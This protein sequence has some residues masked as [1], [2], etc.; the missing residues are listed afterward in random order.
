MCACNVAGDGEAE[1]YALL[2]A[3]SRFVQAREGAEGFLI[4]FLWDAGAVVLDL[5][6]DEILFANN[7]HTHF[8]AM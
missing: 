6:G 7:A 2:V 5:R 4:E 1:A 8:V 3:R